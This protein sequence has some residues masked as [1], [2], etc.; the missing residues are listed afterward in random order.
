VRAFFL[1]IFIFPLFFFSCQKKEKSQTT[2]FELNHFLQNQIK[3]LKKNHAFIIKKI[4]VNNQEKT[5]TIKNPNWEKELQGIKSI[6]IATSIA[7]DYQIDTLSMDSIIFRSNK[8]QS[9]GIEYV[10]V[11]DTKSKRKIEGKIIDVNPMYKYRKEIIFS[12]QKIKEKEFLNEYTIVLSQEVR[13]VGDIYIKQYNQ[14]I[15]K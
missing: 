2:F 5:D 7:K 13:F 4:I 9:K 12:T 3:Q 10:K 1:F 6:D 14:I 8:N 11:I 15:Y